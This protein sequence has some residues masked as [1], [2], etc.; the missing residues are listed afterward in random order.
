MNKPNET[1]T[2]ELLDSI[3]ETGKVQ[4]FFQP[5]VSIQEKSILGFESFARGIAGDEQE[6]VKACVL[7]DSNIDVDTQLKID[8][9]CRNTA[10]KQFQSIYQAHK[11]V[12][13]FLN[14]N[15]TALQSETVEESFL[16]DMIKG[17]GYDPRHIVIEV[18]E[19]KIS[20][21]SSLE[22]LKFHK[23]HGFKFSI[24]NVGSSGLGLD[25]MFLLKPDFI[26]VSRDLFMDIKEK[27]YK[28]AMLETLK[29]AAEELGCALVG[30][31][32]E[33][34][35]EAFILLEAD[36][37]HQQGFFY[38][39]TKGDDSD[40]SPLEIFQEKITHVHN[41]YRERIAQSIT[42]K[43]EMFESY[44]KLSSKIMFKLE[45]A[46]AKEFPEL[47][48]RICTN[49]KEL[50]GMFILDSTGQQLATRMTKVSTPDGKTVLKETSRNTNHSIKDYV[51]YLEMGFEKFVTPPFVSPLTKNRHTI[52]S[53]RFFNNEGGAY[54]ICVEFPYLVD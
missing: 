51:L 18:E 48:K 45:G 31:G 17:Y 10:L 52:I 43:K 44:N 36:I 14:I 53:R 6:V 41:R 1:C 2:K 47:M 34:E 40:K 11:N 29:K 49:I 46:T 54:I 28:A 15:V 38:T 30:K 23:E 3:L 5:V 24:D 7:F 16:L 19:D 37:T 42:N 20:E 8:R 4:A 35:E 21:N 32:V 12:L 50:T 27:P 33:V 25:K 9:L 39:K 26:K 22:L 13:L